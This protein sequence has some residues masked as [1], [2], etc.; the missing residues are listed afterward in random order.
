M[1]ADCKEVKM[2]DVGALPR[3]YTRFK[4]L[5]GNGRAVIREDA[6]KT[7][8]FISTMEIINEAA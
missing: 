1:K 4:K 7:L 5:H 8:G 2:G 6:D 3:D